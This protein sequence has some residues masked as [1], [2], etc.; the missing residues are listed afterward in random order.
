[1]SK[2]VG[3]ASEKPSFF[4]SFFYFRACSQFSRFLK[5]DSILE[6]IVS[7][8]VFWCVTWLYF[9]FF[10]ILFNFTLHDSEHIPWWLV[11]KFIY[12]TFVLQHPIY[13]ELTQSHVTFSIQSPNDRNEELSPCDDFSSLRVQFI[14]WATWFSI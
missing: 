4:H 12:Y 14:N 2:I 11:L 9:I 8:R 1:M 6:L 10:N 3:L 13:D 5:N 7:M